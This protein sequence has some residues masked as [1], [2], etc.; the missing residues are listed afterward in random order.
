MTTDDYLA[1]SPDASRMGKAAE[2]LVAASAILAT[3]G[4]LNVR[5]PWSTMT[6]ST[7]CSIGV[8]TSPRLL[9]R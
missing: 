5:H 7:W 8:T 1:K 9:C 2:Y 3:R 6:A 4:E